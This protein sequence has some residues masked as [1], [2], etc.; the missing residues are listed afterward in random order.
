M[1]LATVS[2][3]LCGYAKVVQTE[4]EPNDKSPISNISAGSTLWNNNTEF[5]PTAPYYAT[6]F[7]PWYP[8]WSNEG[9][10]AP[11]NWFSNYLP[12]P[13]PDVFEPVTEL[14][15]SNDD[16]IIYWQLRK[17]AEAR[18]EVAISSWWGQGHKTDKTFRHILN[19][20]MNR[21]NNP[22]PNLRW[23]L[24]Y[25]KES[26][27]D[28][29]VTELVK[30][31]NYTKQN[32]TNQRG[33]LKIGGRPVIFVY[34]DPK[35]ND[36]MVS[37]WANARAQTGFYVVLRVYSGYQKAQNPPDSWHQ[38]APALRKEIQ[39]PYSCMVSPGFWRDGG[40][41]RLPRDLTA[42]RN[43]VSTMV[44]APVTWKLV[45]TWNEWGEGTAVEPGDQVIQ[46]RKDSTNLDPKGAPFKN[47]YIEVLQELLPPLEQGTGVPGL[48]IIQRRR[49]AGLLTRSR[50]GN[51]HDPRSSVLLI[52]NSKPLSAYRLGSIAQMV[53]ILGGLSC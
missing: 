20:V 32:Y 23:A 26:L 14:Y 19:D 39:A 31:L 41:V 47:H 12:D 18:L 38:Y 17:M 35:D 36:R 3:T 4:A 37:R 25:E 24:Y 7:Y 10:A 5:Q 45:E 34:S 27:G 2:L 1:A 51:V 9:H 53:S 48:S 30:D 52:I 42:F 28:P 29:T 43:A 49:C 50:S 46:A 44:D 16:A 33:Y 22:Y 15:N 11:R 13:K 8:N 6:F 21:P 40:V